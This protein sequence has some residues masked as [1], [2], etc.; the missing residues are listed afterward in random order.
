LFAKTQ[1]KNGVPNYT[2]SK[3]GEQITVID[4]K[5]AAQ[6]YV[7]MLINTQVVAA[8]NNLRNFEKVFKEA[9]A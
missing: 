2:I 4:G 3:D 5:Y 6:T 1:D 8:R 9:N 7:A